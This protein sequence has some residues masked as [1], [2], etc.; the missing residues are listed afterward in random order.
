MLK[1]S[2]T[3]SLTA[4]CCKCLQADRHTHNQCLHYIGNNLYGNL[5]RPF[6]RYLQVEKDANITH[7]VNILQSEMPPKGCRLILKANI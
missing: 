2:F 5:V 3:N 7:K 4:G 1:G 6:H